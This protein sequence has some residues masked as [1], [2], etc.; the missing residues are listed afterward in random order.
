MP[1]NRI[2]RNSSTV[3]DLIRVLA[4]QFVA[5]GHSFWFTDGSLANP[6][7]YPKYISVAMLSTLG[8]F[9]LSGLLI[10]YTC[11]RRANQE[12]YGFRIYF[13]DRFA[14][15]YSGL[16][17]ALLLIFLVNVLHIQIAPL[18]YATNYGAL[19]S[20]DF[21]T[22]VGNILMLQGYPIQAIS[23][24]V[25]GD[26][27]QLWTLSIEWWMYMA[28]GWLVISLA[29]GRLLSLPRFIIPMA[30]FAV[31]PL[32]GLFVTG[33]N[34]V[35]IW[36]LGAGL[37][38]LIL[39]TNITSVLGRWSVAVVLSALILYRSA[40]LGTSIYGDYFLAVLVVILLSALIGLAD[41]QPKE[42]FGH[43]SRLVI[44]YMADYSYT[45]YLVHFSV[46]SL[47][48]A[49]APLGYPIAVTLLALVIAN[50]SAAGLALVM[51]K[52]HRAI[53]ERLKRM[54]GP[55]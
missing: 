55:V 34:L 18:H 5:L 13:I 14:R 35:F 10:G 43:R 40:Q 17:P 20:L 21:S 3:L 32:S 2:A 30:I 48:F 36:L 47:V 6:V 19:G 51:E 1:Q 8:F 33:R 12:D 45:L 23:A 49:V 44:K 50:L 16:L 42:L 41:N 52:R 29:K 53:G 26:A 4:A 9:A 24:P 27:F 39:N 7:R 38:A 46:I 31:V 11:L 25:Y 15:I 28:F 37:A 54:L 22:L